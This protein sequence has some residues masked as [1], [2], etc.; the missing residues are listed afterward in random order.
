VV[1]SG[2]A[3]QPLFTA[4]PETYMKVA[5][6]WSAYTSLALVCVKIGFVSIT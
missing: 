1:L 3:S 6:T 5:Q 2:D 4:L